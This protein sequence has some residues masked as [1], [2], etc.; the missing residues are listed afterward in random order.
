MEKKIGFH[1]NMMYLSENGF[2]GKQ[3]IIGKAQSSDLGTG[4]KKETLLFLFAS[5]TKR[6]STWHMFSGI[7]V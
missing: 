1:P 7:C 4:Q 6:I 2:T 5:L 3:I